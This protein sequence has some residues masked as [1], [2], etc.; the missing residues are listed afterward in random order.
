MMN[1]STVDMLRDMRMNGMANELE[2]QLT[3]PSFNA[4]GFEERLGLLVTAEWNRRQ[5][6]KVNR[7]IRNASFSAPSATVEG[8][9]YYEDRQLDRAQ[10][11]RFSCCQ[12]ID[13][14]RHIILKGASGNGKTYIA[15]ALVKCGLSSFQVGTVYPDAGAAGFDQRCPQLR[16]TSEAAEGV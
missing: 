14:G 13:E 12:Y 10:I 7:Y 6:N 11:L 3:D 5:N 15:C 1:Q 2:A 4:L 9:E 16:R 8:I